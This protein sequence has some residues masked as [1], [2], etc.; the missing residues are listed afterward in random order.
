MDMNVLIFRKV[1]KIDKEV[2]A[3]KLGVKLFLHAARYD[4]PN[5]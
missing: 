4:E 2:Q 3:I 5:H 1:N